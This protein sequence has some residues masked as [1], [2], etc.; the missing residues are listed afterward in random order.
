MT[1]WNPD[2]APL[3]ARETVFDAFS[4][5]WRLHKSI[6]KL[7]APG[8]EELELAARFS[9]SLIN[10]YLFQKEAEKE[11]MPLNMDEDARATLEDLISR[12]EEFIEYIR[13]LLTGYDV[14]C[15]KHADEDYFMERF[16]GCHDPDQWDAIQNLARRLEIWARDYESLEVRLRGRHN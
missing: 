3:I 14:I 10:F 5:G 16:L 9:E 4:L 15:G 13:V 6:G 12:G 2:S 7:Y 11:L 1:K 8:T